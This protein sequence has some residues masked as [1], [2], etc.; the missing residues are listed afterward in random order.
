MENKF[1]AWQVRGPSRG[2]APSPSSRWFSRTLDDPAPPTGTVILVSR[3][4]SDRSVAEMGRLHWERGRTV[5]VSHV[6]SAGSPGHPQVFTGHR[7]QSFHRRPRPFG[8]AGG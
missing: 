8:V 3:G 5:P 4:I 1:A 6:S 7:F 2:V